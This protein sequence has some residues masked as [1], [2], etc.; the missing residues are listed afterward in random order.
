MSNSLSNIEFNIKF[1]DKS[2]NEKDIYKETFYKFQSNKENNR[3]KTNEKYLENLDKHC[4]TVKKETKNPY[5]MYDKEYNRKLSKK[6][7]EAVLSNFDKNICELGNKNVDQ[8]KKLELS[9][10]LIPYCCEEL[11]TFFGVKNK[12][13]DQVNACKLRQNDIDYFE[14]KYNYII[15]PTDHEGILNNDQEFESENDPV[16][17]LNFLLFNSKFNTKKK[18]KVIISHSNFL[19]MFAHVLEQVYNNYVIKKHYKDNKKA[20]NSG[21]LPSD[22][23]DTEKIKKLP[24]FGSINFDNLDILH[25]VINKTTS[26]SPI[27]VLVSAYRFNDDYEFDDNFTNSNNY[28]HIF[29]MRHCIACH[30]LIK[31]L[32][33]KGINIESSKY[34][35]CIP[36]NFEDIIS[37][38][39]NIIRLFS[40]YGAT[41]FDKIEFG[42]SVNFRAVLTSY[43]LQLILTNTSYKLKDQYTISDEYN[44]EYLCNVNNI[45]Q[46]TLNSKNLS[47]N[48]LKIIESNFRDFLY[49]NC[50]FYINIIELLKK[51]QSINIIHYNY[52]DKYNLNVFRKNVINI[53]SDDYNF[54]ENTL[55]EYI[56]LFNKLKNLDITLSTKENID[57]IINKI[58]NLLVNILPY[59]ESLPGNIISIFVTFLGSFLYQV[60]DCLNIYKYLSKKIDKPYL[61]YYI[62]YLE[63]NK[64]DKDGYIE[65]MSRLLYENI[66]KNDYLILNNNI[67]L[68]IQSSRKSIW[69]T[70]TQIKNSNEVLYIQDLLIIYKFNKAKQI[71]DINIQNILKNAYKDLDTK[72][73]YKKEILEKVMNFLF[74]EENKNILSRYLSLPMDLSIPS[75]RPSSS[76]RLRSMPSSLQKQSSQ[77]QTSLQRQRSMPSSLH[78]SPS[79]QR[80]RSIPSQRQTSNTS[81]TASGV[82]KNL[83]RKSEKAKK[84]K[85]EKSE[86]A[87][88]QKSEK[89]KKRKSEKRKK[90]EKKKVLNK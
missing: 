16:K 46:E 81:V 28:E 20:E 61:I 90:N 84:Q 51:K 88:K 35:M 72:I 79:L 87:K 66:R 17:F 48:K 6:Y 25:L 50:D 1:N 43:I 49:T 56:L 31:D 36:Q 13:M 44:I 65:E 76:Q 75:Y 69:E 80:L 59:N 3:I 52:Y 39:D 54:V 22:I 19:T 62:R 82:K 7:L 30:N 15:R 5:M 37:Q 47:G 89:A 12:K 74:D 41:D 63:N 42:S 21:L 71:S 67:H 24:N 26:T 85:S 60:T 10:S 11:K 45:I 34:S 64:I 70:I 57:T 55:D 18:H 29:I 9:N 2:L 14:G 77:H 40:H 27:I 4:K 58:N 68:L 53:N 78:R 23:I 33:T 73:K 8:L 83:K 86:K 38:K 32:Y